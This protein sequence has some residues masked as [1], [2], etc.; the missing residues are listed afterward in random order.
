MRLRR[1]PP[2]TVPGSLIADPDSPAPHYE[3]MQYGLQNF[4]EKPDATLE[5]AIACLGEY[6][7]TWINIE[8]LGDVEAIQRIGKAYKLHPLALE[9]VV[10]VHQRPKLE[11]YQDVLF[12]IAR[13]PHPEAIP[14]TEQVAFFLGTNFLIT[15]QEGTPGD[16]F[17]PVRK[18]IREDSGRLRH[19]SSAYLL[20]ALLD[21]L[22][23]Q[24]FP[25]LEFYA[26][27]LQNI[28][29]RIIAHRYGTVSTELYT[30]RRHLLL[31]HRIVRPLQDVINALMREPLNIFD[32]ETRWYL[33]DVFDHTTQ[34]MDMLE[35]YKDLSTHLME[36]AST[37]AGA[38]MN[39]IM[40]FLTVMSSIFIP[41]TF[42]AGVYGMNFKTEISPMNMPELSWYYGYPFSLL[43]MSFISIGLMMFFRHKGWL[44]VPE[45]DKMK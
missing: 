44:G 32:E 39:E 17:E 38:R 42:I 12:I 8:G 18:H 14:A 31:M 26:D 23:D 24:F 28:E 41:L 34:L 20:Y 19:A 21:T 22:V 2:G 27:L 33:R 4:V 36:M 45:S 10:N 7:I 16:C 3:I 15:F 13:M 9:D 40:R 43:L 1:S 35:T 30:I 5:E 11:A 29:D 37:A 6:P 25:Q